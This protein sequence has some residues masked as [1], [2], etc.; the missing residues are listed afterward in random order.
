MEAVIKC[1]SGHNPNAVGDH[2]YSF[3]LVQIYLPAHPDI[4]K[5]QALDPEFALDFLASHLANR[6]GYFWT[7]WRNL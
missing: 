6:Q 1:E 2:G 4:S 5:E 3:G 7:C